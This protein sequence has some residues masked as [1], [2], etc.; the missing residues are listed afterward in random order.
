MFINFFTALFLMLYVYFFTT[1][2][3]HLGKSASVFFSII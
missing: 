3:G 1:F 2:M